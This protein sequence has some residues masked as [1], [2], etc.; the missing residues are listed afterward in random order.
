MNTIS[1]A[2]FDEIANSS[3]EFG[4]FWR[5]KRSRFELRCNCGINFN[6]R[7]IY[8]VGT[9]CCDIA[10]ARQYLLDMDEDFQI[11]FD[12][13]VGEYAIITDYEL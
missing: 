2:E 4:P 3:M 7:R 11:F 6:F 8:W 10:K 1:S 5:T 13:G 9:R 12:N